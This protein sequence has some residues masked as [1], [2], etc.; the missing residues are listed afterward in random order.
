[1]YN[2]AINGLDQNTAVRTVVK[3][4]DPGG[5]SVAMNQHFTT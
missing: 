1:M 5:I 2:Y 4:A 3:P